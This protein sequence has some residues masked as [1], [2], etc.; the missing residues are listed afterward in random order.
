MSDQVSI[1]TH[2][3]KSRVSPASLI[4]ISDYLPCHHRQRAQVGRTQSGQLAYDTVD[5]LTHEP[6]TARIGL[7]G[8]SVV[9]AKLQGFVS[10]FFN[11]SFLSFTN[12]AFC[13]SV[14]TPHDEMT[15]QADRNNLAYNKQG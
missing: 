4:P 2:K 8:N 5:L 13:A 10:Q 9:R 7:Y 14:K 3:R 6:P 11:H 1:Y 15:F 12:C